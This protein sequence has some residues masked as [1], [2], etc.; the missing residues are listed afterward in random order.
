MFTCSC[1]A[2]LEITSPPLIS[3]ASMSYREF[4]GTGTSRYNMRLICT[5]QVQTRRS[6]SRCNQ[7]ASIFYKTKNGANDIKNKNKET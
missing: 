7:N 2:A 4:N 1:C 3:F 6:N 5:C